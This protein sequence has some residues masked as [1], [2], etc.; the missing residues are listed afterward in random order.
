MGS[1][2]GP[3]RPDQ[4]GCLGH[5]SLTRP[6]RAGQAGGVEQAGRIRPTAWAGLAE[7]GWATAAKGVLGFARSGFK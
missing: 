2:V 4:P 6:G 5:A 3:G 1:V 7:L